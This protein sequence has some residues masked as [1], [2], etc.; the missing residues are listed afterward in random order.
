MKNGYLSQWARNVSPSPTLAVDSKAKAMKPTVKGGK[1]SK[2]VISKEIEQLKKHPIEGVIEL[3]Q[4]L[5]CSP[6]FNS[7]MKVQKT[8]WPKVAIA[9]N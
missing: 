7:G 3:L 5:A 6:T 2:K 1:V 9:A 8:C 4:D